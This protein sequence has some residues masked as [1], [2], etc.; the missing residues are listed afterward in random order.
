[1]KKT[2]TCLSILVL[3]F[4]ISA[5]TLNGVLD[6]IS[7]FSVKKSVQFTMPDGTHLETDIFLPIT[8]DSMMVSIN[9]PGLGPTPVQVIPKGIQYLIYDSINNGLNPNPFQLPVLLTRTPYNKQSSAEYGNIVSLLGFCFAMQDMR[10]CYASEGAYYPMYSDSWNKNNY[11]P[12]VKHNLDITDFSDSRNGNKHEDGFNSIVFITDSL[13]RI[14]DLD[15]DGIKDTFLLCN[16]TVGMFGSSAS[17]NSQYT[18]A[19][20][21]KINPTAPGLKSLFAIV[22][23]A[24]Q[25]WVTMVQNGVYRQAIVDNWVKRQLQEVNDEA[26]NSSD[27]SIDN[28]IHSF[29]DYGLTNAD[30]AFNATMA[31]MLDSSNNGNIPAYYP[32]SLFRYSMDASKASVNSDGEGDIN[33]NYSRYS[34]MDVPMFHLTGW[35]DIFVDGQIHTFNQTVNN[36]NNNHGNKS[37]QKLVIGLWAHQTVTSRKTGDITYP[38]NVLSLIGFNMSNVDI[39]STTEEN[40][41]TS[42]IYKWFRATLNEKQGYSAPKFFI[43]EAT[44]WQALSPT[45]SVRVPAQDYIIPYS[46][47]IG[48]LCGLQELSGVPIEVKIN[49]DIN[50]IIFNAPVI[51]NPVLNINGSVPSGTD[52]YFQNIAN[53]RFYVPGPVNDGV[54]ENLNVGNY[55]FE[56]DSFPISENINYTDFYLQN[57]QCLSPFIP[58]S[59]EGTVSF[60]HDPN[61]PVLTVGGAN[62]TVKTP[63]NSRNSQGQMNLAHPDFINYTMNHQGVV[64]FMS[65]TIADSLCIIGFPKATIYASSHIE[66]HN[67]VPTNTDFFV[68]ILDV[69]PTG[70][71]YFVVE[72]CINA[73]AREYVRTKF[74]G[75]ENPDAEFS[76]ITSDAFYKYEFD[77]LP[78]AYTFGKNHRIKILISSGNYPRYMSSPN[79]PLNENEFFKRKPNDGK[80]YIFNGTE[81]SPRICTNSVAF[82]S[83]QPS[84][85]SLPIYGGFTINKITDSSLNEPKIDIFPNPCSDKITIRLD[86]NE[87]SEITVFGIDGRFIKQLNS[88][89]LT[90]IDVRHLSFGIYII[91][92]TNQKYSCVSR[93]IKN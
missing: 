38:E 48:Y 93:F 16:G 20:A 57:N 65:E 29:A 7:D 64:K 47:F 84:H 46:E 34:N 40:I 80:K 1:M 41:F 62:M 22:A 76:N 69:Y 61:N 53:V 43:P 49:G 73:R 85:I 75:N 13:T 70:E 63:D 52:G 11:H 19:A 28:T 23:T 36:I 71:E 87:I 32:N 78:I 90:E 10:G 33:E 45:Y 17:G 21:H 66:G 39:L 8:Q 9:I 59:E 82:S 83:N 56:S 25:Y 35:W 18:A 68:R 4:A 81:M 14:Y 89:G 79:L 77:L 92:I 86:V 74:N 5:Q 15:R 54:S 31:T 50:T 3:T 58:D 27:F 88:S 51:E 67:S 2:F 60:T 6:E 37:F 30:E 12:T 24:D 44:Q 55:W 26:L 72:G 91:R 42:E